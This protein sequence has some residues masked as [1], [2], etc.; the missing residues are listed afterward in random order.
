MSCKRARLSRGFTGI[1]SSVVLSLVDVSD[2]LTVHGSSTIT[3][4]TD[5]LTNLRSLVSNADGGEIE[6]ASSEEFI[7]AHRAAAARD[8]LADFLSRAVA[9]I[10]HA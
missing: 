1:D 2:L 7:P 6:P 9:E 10:L 5:G 4:F 3:Y 8:P